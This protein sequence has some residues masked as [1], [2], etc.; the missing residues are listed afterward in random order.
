MPKK[1]LPDVNG[2]AWLSHN[3]C[4]RGFRPLT[5]EESKTV[6]ARLELI[7]SSSREGRELGFIFSANGL[8]V[9][10]WTSFVQRDGQA[11][12]QDSG[13]VLIRDGDRA[14]YFARPRSRTLNFLQNLLEDACIARQRVIHRPTCPE[15]GCKQ[16]MRIARGS[17]LKS[18]F[19]RCFR[20]EYHSKAVKLP[21]D[22]G[23]PPEVLE[24]VLKRRK[25]RV[26]AGKA[27]LRR[28]GWKVG[29]PDNLVPA[30]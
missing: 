9:I 23:L 26:A 13:W 25:A 15:P 30:K 24:R 5:K 20:P 22:F 14:R 6:F 19:W 21:W 27:M 4:R 28:K 11:R 16:Q 8:D 7:P 10:V 3:L 1:V 12:E 29:R 2:I 17:G 18:R